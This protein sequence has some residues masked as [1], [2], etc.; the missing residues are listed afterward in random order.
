MRDLRGWTLAILAWTLALMRPDVG[1]A[2]E[3]SGRIVMP[4]G[5]RSYVAFVPQG[6]GRRLPTVIALHGA[7]M[8]GRGMQRSFGLDAVAEREGFIAVYPDGVYRR[9]NDGRRPPWRRADGTDDVGFLTRLAKRLVDDGFADPKRLYLLGVSNG[10]MMAFRVA[11]EAPGTFTAYTAIVA[12]MPANL[13]DRCRPRKGVP[14][15]IM[16]STKDPLIPWAGGTLGFAGRHGRVVSTEESLDFWRRNNGCEGELQRRPLPDKDRKDGST[17]LAQQYNRCKS[18]APVVLITIEGGGHLPPGATIGA[19]VLVE[20][21]LGKANRD[22][23]AADISWKFFR[24][25]PQDAGAAS[26]AR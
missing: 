26:S 19:R 9:W 10:G 11:C 22:I 12:N 25:F 13:T 21:I 24:R 17:V 8:D 18:G 15:L 6:K 5:Q 1:H 23:S 4:D 3:I 14:M 7:V 2:E 20:A 16:N